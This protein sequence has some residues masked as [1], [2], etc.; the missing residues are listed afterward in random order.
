MIENQRARMQGIGIIP[1]VPILKILYK[2]GVFIFSLYS[3]TIVHDYNLVCIK[4]IFSFL[5][6]LI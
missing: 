4:N 5:S 6:K 3:L 1:V 2:A